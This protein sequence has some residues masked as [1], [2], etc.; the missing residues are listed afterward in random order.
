MAISGSASA[1]SRREFHRLEVHA[2]ET[3]DD[4]E[5]AQLLG[6]DV[7]EQ[8]FAL[9]VLAIESLDRILHRRGELAVGAAELLQQHVAEARIG[10]VDPD[11]VHELLDVVIHGNPRCGCVRRC[12]GGPIG[13]Q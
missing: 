13:K 3:A 8:V 5:M 11:G 2:G 12:V 9:R 4:L 6:A 1:S 10:L 7:H